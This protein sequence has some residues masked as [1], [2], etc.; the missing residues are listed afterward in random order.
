[1]DYVDK[2][3]GELINYLENK[4]S[5]NEDEEFAKVQVMLYL[6]QTC[7]TDKKLQE[8]LNNLESVKRLNLT[9]RNFTI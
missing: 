4:T 6:Y 1:M 3:V 2:I 7:N 9:K 5:S 8:S